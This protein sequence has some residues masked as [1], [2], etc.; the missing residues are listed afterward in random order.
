MKLM[1][2]LC[3]VALISVT[4]PAF[5]D[6]ITDAMDAARKAYQGGDLGGAKQQLD[7]ASTLI[8]QKNAEGF[9][10]LLPAPLPGWT[11]EKA[12]S[13]AVGAAVFGA[14]SA[15]RVYT[16]AKGDT[17]DV[18]ITGDSAM[19]SQLAPALGNPAMAAM[20][21]KIVRVGDQRAIQN[22]DGD[23]MVLVS[24]KFLV[25]VTGSG[26]AASKLAYAQAVNFAKLTK[27]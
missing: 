12:Q 14:S 1:H 15:S 19:I 10:A 16:N 22:N 4:A 20:M 18:S 23:V 3:A 5:A 6:D 21:G 2:V 9:A 26:D 11:A 17:V 25:N 13:Q 7:L 27:M 8:G 24:N